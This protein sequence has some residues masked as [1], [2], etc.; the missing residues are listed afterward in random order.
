MN[1]RK[2]NLLHVPSIKMERQKAIE[3]PSPGTPPNGR[4]FPPNG[5]NSALVNGTDPG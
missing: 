4:N 3:E 2:R 5:Q 1:T